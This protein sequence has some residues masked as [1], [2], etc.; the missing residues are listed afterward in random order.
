MTEFPASQV[1]L[2]E[3]IPN[4]KLEINLK[5]GMAN[6]PAHMVNVNHHI[7]V[8]WTIDL[9]PSDFGRL[10]RLTQPWTTPHWAQHDLWYHPNC[11][12]PHMA[13]SENRIPQ[14][15]PVYNGNKLVVNRVLSDTATYNIELVVC[16]ISPL[17]SLFYPRKLNWYP[18]QS[19]APQL[20]VLVCLHPMT[21]I[22]YIYVQRLLNLI[23]Y[24][25]IYL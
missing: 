2:P 24:S 4:K 5:V 19:G 6:Q 22:T 23:I 15:P 14:N 16:P 12:V 8:G 17:L 1:W 10:P 13:L 21:D 9:P 7:V 3:G 11:Q 20:C 25:F 18:I